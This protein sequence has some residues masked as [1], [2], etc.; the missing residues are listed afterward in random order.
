M[1]LLDTDVVS[2]PLR[3]SPDIRVIGWID[4]QTMETLFLSVV[5]MAELRAGLAMPP[6]GKR[7]QQSLAGVLPA[8]A[9]SLSPM[10][11]PSR[12][13]SSG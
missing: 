8:C 13:R 9:L 1:I 11:W 10:L 7:R 4:A 12:P 5:T 3:P 2:E 6:P